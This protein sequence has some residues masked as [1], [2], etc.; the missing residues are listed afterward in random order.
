M[1]LTKKADADSYLGSEKGILPPPPH[2][3]LLL[4]VGTGIFATDYFFSLLKR[5]I[6][7]SESLFVEGG[8]IK[9][10]AALN[11]I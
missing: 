7:L 2:F 3:T 1:A 10:S 6:Y 4:A 8:I 5:E 11:L 9:L